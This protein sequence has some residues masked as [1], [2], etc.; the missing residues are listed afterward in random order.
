MLTTKDDILISIIV[1]CRNEENYIEKCINSLVTQKNV[2]GAFEII[3]VDGMSEDGTMS[4]LKRL[5]FNHSSI[6]IFN[7]E[8]KVKPPAV[9]IGFN[10]AKGKYIAICD[11][12]S[13]Y[14]V[15]YISNCIKV[16]RDDPLIWCTGGPIVSVGESNFGK[17]N[18]IAMAS[19]IGVGNAKHRFPNYEGFAEMACFPVFNRV[20]L[21]KVGYYD[22]FFDINHDDEYCHRLRQNGGKVYLT[23]LAKSYYYVRNSVISLFKQYYSYGLWQVAFLKKHKTPISLRQ[24]VPISFFSIVIVFFMVGIIINNILLAIVLPLFYLGILFSFSL[25]IIFKE[26]FKISMSFLLAVFILHFSYATGFFFGFFKFFSKK[27]V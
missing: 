14:D 21:E 10:E 11:A 20:V 12:H 26:G 25:P 2:H 17:A 1:C 27:F 6:R 15:Y 13:E 23:P 8:K 3:V 18:A 4:I 16:F 7:N 24:I 22:D 19:P 5:A 9:N